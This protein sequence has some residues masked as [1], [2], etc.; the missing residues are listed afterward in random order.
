M[1]FARNVNQD[2]I[3][4]RLDLYS[5]GSD[6]FSQ[7]GTPVAAMIG[8]NVATGAS[9]YGVGG[10]LDGKTLIVNGIT[11]TC[12]GATNTANSTAFLAAIGATIT[13]VTGTL[14]GA[15]ASYLQLT[16]PGAGASIVIGA[17][18]AN[19]LLGF[20][21]IT[22]SNKTWAEYLNDLNP[23]YN[24]QNY[25]IWQPTNLINGGSAA[26]PYVPVARAIRSVSGG[27][28]YIDTLWTTKQKITLGP[29][30][31]FYGDIVAIYPDTLL[32]DIILFA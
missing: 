22:K 14:G 3:P 23:N 24:C 30:E 9:L 32:T 10:G 18:T 29:L 19:T 12:N 8:T 15:N 13:G 16:K 5:V 17:G 2:S 27:D 6:I 1:Q 7:I 4:C 20:T 28:I 11:L 26:N 21:Q 31:K 25:A